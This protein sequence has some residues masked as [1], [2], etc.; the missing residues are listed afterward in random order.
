MKTLVHNHT[1]KKLFLSVLIVILNGCSVASGFVASHQSTA[2][3]KTIQ[4]DRGRC[5]SLA[6]AALT[7]IGPFCPF[8]SNAVIELEEEGEEEQQQQQQLAD[9]N[10]G[11]ATATKPGFAETFA[12]IQ[13]Q[14]QL[15]LSPNPDTLRRVA[16]E[17]ETA[18]DRWD[19]LFVE[20]PRSTPDFCTKEYA[21]MAETHLNQHGTSTRVI[22]LLVRW[23]SGCLR[24]LAD[25]RPAPVPPPGLDLNS[26]MEEAKQRAL[27]SSS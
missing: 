13:S 1:M 20:R 2:R 16:G 26:M 25:N 22:A 5:S 17:M 19:H 10:S 24:A 12:R 7:P 11:S 21:A 3:Q 4:S 6:M 8:R 27:A 23:Q 18:M 15:G 14:M 9:A